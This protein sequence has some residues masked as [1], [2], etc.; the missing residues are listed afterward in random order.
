MNEKDL[1]LKDNK[2]YR[3]VHILEDKLLVIDCIKRDELM[4][5][6]KEYF[7]HC[8]LVNQDYLLE[9]LDISFISFNDMT[10]EQ[11][12][13][14]EKNYDSICNLVMCVKSEKVFNAILTI[15]SNILGISKITLKKRIF[16][17]IA[18]NDIGILVPR[19]VR[20]KKDLTYVM[21]KVNNLYN[22]K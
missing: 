9:K 8:E 15:N 11:K 5:V 3:I 19:L 13:T 21:R 2:I 14:A 6:E 20:K 10:A 1:Y 17:Y 22:R 18:I 7:D 16:K 12:R 4:W